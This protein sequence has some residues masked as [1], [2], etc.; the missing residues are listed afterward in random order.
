MD[1]LFVNN[2]LH[3][4]IE[5]YKYRTVIYKGIQHYKNS[6]ISVAKLF[7]N[8]LITSHTFVFPVF[9][10]HQPVLMEPLNF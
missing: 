3:S 4:F 8:C 7:L 9:S 2:V 10:Q 6:L 5:I 1:H